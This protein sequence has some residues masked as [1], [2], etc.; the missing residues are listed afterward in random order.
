MWLKLKPL[1]ILVPPGLR[2]GTSVIM[3]L[4]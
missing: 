2:L 4:S 3:Y 1:L